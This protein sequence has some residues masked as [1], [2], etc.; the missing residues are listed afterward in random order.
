[1]TIYMSDIIVVTNRSICQDDFIF[2][3]ERLAKAH[4]KAIVLRE[5][6]LS[7]TEYKILAQKVIEICNRNKTKCVLH[8]FV[9]VCLELKQDSVHLPIDVLHGLSKDE[10]SAFKILGASCHSADDAKLAEK[11]GCTYITAGH[12]FET[13]CKK[14]LPAKGIDF[15]KEIN[16][17]VNIPVYAIGGINSQNIKEIRKSGASGACVMSSAMLCDDPFE[18]LGTFEGNDEF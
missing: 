11:L 6:D 1:M 5:K 16:K 2:R 8:N 14:G 15:L 18:F 12:I 13:D 10:R 7:E 3:I 9:S 4:P 17:C